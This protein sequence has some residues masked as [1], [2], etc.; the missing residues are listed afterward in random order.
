MVQEEYNFILQNFWIIHFCVE[1]D[2]VRSIRFDYSFEESIE[3]LS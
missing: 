2:F 1:T 3:F